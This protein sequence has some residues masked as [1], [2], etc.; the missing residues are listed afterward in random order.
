MRIFKSVG[1]GVGTAAGVA[2]PLFGIVSSS[3]GFVAGS[4]SSIIL[5]S[6]SSGLFLFVALPV[7]I[8]S[9]Q[10]YLREKNELSQKYLEKQN[11]T[12]EMLFSLLQAM[13]R[14]Y[15]FKMVSNDLSKFENDEIINYLIKK[16]NK[17]K[18]SL[19]ETSPNTFL[20]LDDI[21]NNKIKLISFVTQLK[22][23]NDID[24]CSMED[25]P[26]L[27][28]HQARE[29]GS[30]QY[31]KWNCRNY[32]LTTSYSPHLKIGASS[33]FGAFGT[34]LGC[35]AGLCGMLSGVGLF[36]GFAAVPFVGWAAL[37]GSILFGLGIGIICTYSSLQKNKLEQSINYYEDVSNNLDKQQCILNKKVDT[38][39][40]SKKKYETIKQLICP[41]RWKASEGNLQMY[42]NRSN[43]LFFN[44][45]CVKK[46]LPAKYVK[47]TGYNN[48]KR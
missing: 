44:R 16:I 2:W 24:S 23:Q 35:T 47:L 15:L 42:F 27:N 20:L 4:L 11:N 13:I 14:N 1:D 37:A 18:T 33:F 43:N 6:I 31:V 26:L 29:S 10:D 46:Q 21:S 30:K 32:L 5:G 3:L 48:S 19:R 9:Y 41:K 40:K 36:A 39:V 17:I 22:D 12:Y 38:N 45:R 34:I 8:W 25:E 28:T 7:A